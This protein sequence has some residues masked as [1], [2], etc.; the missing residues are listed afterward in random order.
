MWLTGGSTPRTDCPPGC[1]QTRTAMPKLTKAVDTMLD[2]LIS[3]VVL[4]QPPVQVRRDGL[5]LAVSRMTGRSLANS[6]VSAG[7]VDLLMD[8]VDENGT[9]SDSDLTVDVKVGV[10]R[11]GVV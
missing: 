7:T 8:S 4:G 1:P 2:T 10:N 11:D 3:G 9:E 6:T 5:A